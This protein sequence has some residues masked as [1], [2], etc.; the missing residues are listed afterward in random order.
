[1]LFFNRTFLRTDLL[2]SLLMSAVVAILILNAKVDYS[3]SDPFVSM[4]SAQSI[5]DS[6]TMDL[7]PYKELHGLAFVQKIGDGYYDYFPPGTAIFSTPFVALYKAAG[8]DV[9]SSEGS[10]MVQRHIAAL[11]AAICVL[12]SFRVARNWLSV[13]QSAL[14]TGVLFLGSSL[15]STMGTALWNVNFTVLW[16]LCGLA[17]L[18][19]RTTPISD[20]R[21]LLLGFCL[22][23]AFLCRPTAAFYILF[24]F[25]ILLF[26]SRRA[27]AMTMLISAGLLAVFSMVS[28]RELGTVLPQYYLPSRLDSSLFWEA[29]QG[30]T[31]SPSRGLFVFSPF[32]VLLL[33]AALVYR[34]KAPGW[35]LWGAII[36]VTLHLIVVSRFPHWWAGNSYGTRLLTDSMPGWLLI[37]IFGFQAIVSRAKQL[38]I[39]VLLLAS[40][41]SI[42]SNTVQGL[43]NPYSLEW[44]KA[45]GV[46]ENPEQLFDW[47]YPQFLHDAERHTERYK[48]FLDKHNLKQQQH[49]ELDRLSSSIA[50]KENGVLL[51]ENVSG[52]LFYGPYE[53]LIAGDYQFAIGA[54]YVGDKT[55]VGRWD[56]VVH[57]SGEGAVL[58][59]GAWSGEGTIVRGGFR[60]PVE[61]TL[62][63]IEVRLFFSGEGMATARSLTIERL[64]TTATHS[65]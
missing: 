26:A 45:P 4:Y 51:A 25:A 44:N 6:G 38:W 17:I 37:S 19:S 1:M 50:R 55:D 20:R 64:E 24:V 32:L 34:D 59:E 43:F 53:P 56:V 36:W 28:Y 10:R 63:L 13:G 2:V 60:I 65:E 9:R 35:L 52:Y 18:T 42:Y 39:A 22:F 46:D 41:L 12:L 40:S 15:T 3:D 57:H 54:E 11:V 49:F 33:A 14:L 23:A 16:M 48:A 47:N 8:V 7:S 62:G 30:N 27:L 58:A 29:I 31:I 61:Q 21:A 5:V